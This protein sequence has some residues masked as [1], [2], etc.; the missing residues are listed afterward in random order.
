MGVIIAV[1][2]VFSVTSGGGDAPLA[3]VGNDFGK[4]ADI[5]GLLAFIAVIIMFIK[6]IVSENK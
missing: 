5:L 6:R 3:L 4:T 2:I 1:I